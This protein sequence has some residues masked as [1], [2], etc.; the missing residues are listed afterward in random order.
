MGCVV[1]NGVAKDGMGL[2]DNR[3]DDDDACEDDG[4][5]SNV[6]DK[7]A[8]VENSSGAAVATTKVAQREATMARLGDGADGGT[9]T[10]RVVPTM[11]PTM[12]E[13]E[14]QE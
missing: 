8:R 10:E 6:A 2:Q 5:D 3:R 9:D 14:R 1:A 7:W 4:T 13:V 11:V 12:V